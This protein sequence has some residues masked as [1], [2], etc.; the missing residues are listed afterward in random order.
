MP[1]IIAI[2][3]VALLFGGLGFAV[4]ALWIVALVVFVAWILGF[5]LRSGSSTGSR[6]R[7]YRW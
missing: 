2:L 3:I 4:H 7:W 6:G 1:L 5:V